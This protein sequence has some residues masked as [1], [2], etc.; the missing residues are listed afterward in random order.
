MKF[1]TSESDK[2]KTGAS[3]KGLKTTSRTG[4]N[5][6]ILSQTNS[7]KISMIPPQITIIQENMLIFEAHKT[8]RFGTFNKIL[9]TRIRHLGKT[10]NNP[11]IKKLTYKLIKE[12][13]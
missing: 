4:K 9:D 11:S 5:N 8:R 3:R 12:L 6:N 13:I 7:D 1:K 2:D 10:K